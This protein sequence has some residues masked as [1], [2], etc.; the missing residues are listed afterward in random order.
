[1]TATNLS[2]YTFEYVERGSGEPLAL[3]KHQQ[4]APQPV[5]QS[6]REAVLKPEHR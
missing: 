5:R 2:D 4:A 3:A 6:A 1:V